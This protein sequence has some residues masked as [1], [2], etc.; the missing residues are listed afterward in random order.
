ML[1]QWSWVSL[2]VLGLEHLPFLWAFS[3]ATTAPEFHLL[4]N[5]KRS[6]LDFASKDMQSL[7]LHGL[8]PLSHFLAGECLCSIPVGKGSVLIIVVIVVIIAAPVI[9]HCDPKRLMK[10]RVY[11]GRSSRGGVHDCGGDMEGR[12]WSSKLR[13]L[14]SFQGKG[15]EERVDSRY[16]KTWNASCLFSSSRS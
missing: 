10:E 6:L 13:G 15:W 3:F 4:I 1:A 12:S 8:T 14:S 7:V 16:F 5:S 9:K 11:S 2:F